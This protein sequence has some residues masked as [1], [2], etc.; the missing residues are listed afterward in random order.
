MPP[1]DDA[2]DMAL[3][4]ATLIVSAMLSASVSMATAS[5]VAGRQERGRIRLAARHDVRQAVAGHLR[6]ARAA[7]LD[8]P[9]PDELPGEALAGDYRFA[10]RVLAAAEGLGWWRQKVVHHRTRQVTGDFA[11]ELAV[12]VPAIDGVDATDTLTAALVD[13]A[14]GRRSGA[15]HRGGLH[16]AAF[17]DDKNMNYDAF[18]ALIKQLQ[19]ISRCRWW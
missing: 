17:G 3:D 6:T 7:T 13:A 11:F 1:P 5:A 18:P 2:T 8:V 12:D 15:G 10:S 19:R 9:V 16:R 14:N 4:P